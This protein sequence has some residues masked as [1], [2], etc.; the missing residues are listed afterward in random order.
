MQTISPNAN[1]ALVKQIAKFSTAKA[2][3]LFAPRHVD[4]NSM[5]ATRNKAIAEVAEYHRVRPYLIVATMQEDFISINDIVGERNSRQSDEFVFDIK[6]M[7]YASNATAISE[8]PKAYTAMR[9]FGGKLYTC[10]TTKRID[11]HSYVFRVV[12]KGNELMGRIVERSS[13]FKCVEGK[14]VPLSRIDVSFIVCEDTIMWNDQPLHDALI[15]I[16]DSKMAT[17][18]TIN[19][20]LTSGVPGCGKTT[21]LINKFDS[22][23][24]IAVFPTRASCINFAER[25]RMQYIC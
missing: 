20:D 12:R 22:E 13:Y 11:Q 4:S 15:K 10:G 19:V 25:F 18:P 17:Y 14:Y 21:F 5:H 9:V 23:K 24:D 6:R 1:T 8:K 7:S 16:V 3:G 2:K